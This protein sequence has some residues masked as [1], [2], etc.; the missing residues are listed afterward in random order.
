M[1]RRFSRSEWVV[2][3]KPPVYRPPQS[4]TG[5]GASGLA[6][7]VEYGKFGN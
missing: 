7:Q 5:T 2:P 6:F 3:T 4:W 1:V